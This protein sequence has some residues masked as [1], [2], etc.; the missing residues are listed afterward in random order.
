MQYTFQADAVEQSINSNNDYSYAKCLL[1]SYAV[2]VTASAG[3]VWLLDWTKEWKF[4]PLVILAAALT[5]GIIGIQPEQV[6]TLFPVINP[7]WLSE[8]FGMLGISG[9]AIA[10]IF[11]RPCKLQENN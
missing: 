1:V 7:L 2:G 6:I 10:V 11:G 8:A 5:A 3:L 9:I 4:W